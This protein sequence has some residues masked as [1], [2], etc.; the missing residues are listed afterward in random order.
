MDKKTCTKCGTEKPTSEFSA[1][2]VAKDGLMSQ[3]KECR[4]A[5][6]KSYLAANKD[7]VNKRRRDGYD[8]S[9]AHSKYIENHEQSK[10]YHR[11]STKRYRQSVNG[12]LSQRLTAAKSRAKERGWEFDLDSQ[13]LK[14]LWD[15]QEG[16]C[17]LTHIAFQLPTQD[18]DT[19]LRPYSPSLDRIDNL[20]GYTKDNV[21]LV[22]TAINYALNEH[23]EEVFD[24]LARAYLNVK[25]LE[26]PT[27]TQAPQDPETS[28]S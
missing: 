4:N 23:G 12:V 21:R 7:T 24:I 25:G 20:K 17:A 22:C 14:E 26:I 2:P 28:Q 6:Q 15:R 27:C 16:K 18:R 9:E 11:E 3:C 1:R 13:W 19:H 5:K 10:K 8:P